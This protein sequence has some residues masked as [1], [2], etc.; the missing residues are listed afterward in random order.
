M[1]IGLLPAAATHSV[2][3]ICYSESS[4][5]SAS[6]QQFLCAEV[7]SQK[8]RHRNFDHHVF[9]LGQGFSTP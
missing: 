1:R 9:S 8:F 7:L 2:I 4:L 6:C 5:Q 3:R